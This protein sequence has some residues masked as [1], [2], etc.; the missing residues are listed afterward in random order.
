M[1]GRR[2]DA[3]GRGLDTQRLQEQ[4]QEKDQEQEQEQEQHK[5]SEHARA[6]NAFGNAAL[7]AMLANRAEGMAGDEGGGGGQSARRRSH[8]KEG[9]DYGGD[10]DVIDD[11]PISLDDLTRSWNP[12]TRKGEDKPRF[13]E[14]M[15]DDDLPPEDEAFLAD[16]A[17]APRVG[18]LPR[19]QT[20]DPLFEPSREVLITSTAA[21]SRACARF[22]APTPGWRAL[23][24]LVSE[25]PPVLQARGARVLPARAAVAA[26]GSCILAAAP[27]VRHAPT[28]ETGA[29]IHLCLELEGRHRR[30]DNILVQLEEQ[31]ARLPR[32]VALIEE[33][34]RPAGAPL[35][36]TSTPPG[37]AAPLGRSLST[38]TRWV[39]LEPTVPDFQSPPAP[40]P[41]PD[42]PLGL[43]AVFLDKLGPGPEAEAEIARAALRHAERLAGEASRTRIRWSAVALLVDEVSAAW[44]AHP[45]PLLLT[46]AR[47]LDGEVD[48]LL[49]LL[50]EVARACQQHTQPP[51]ALRNGLVRGARQLDGLRRQ[52][53]ELM[54]RLL[55]A[56]LPGHPDL[57][58]PRR[59]RPDPLTAADHPRDALPWARELPAGPDRDLAVLALLARAEASPAAL[60]AAA[61]PLLPDPLEP[62]IDPAAA[63]ALI[64]SG[65]A[66]LHAGDATTV[67]RHADTL[68]VLGRARRN[69]ILVAEAALLSM[70]A[71]ALDDHLDDAAFVRLEAARVCRALDAR[72]ALTLLARWRPHDED[73]DEADFTPFF[74][75]PFV[76]PLEPE[77]GEDEEEDEDEDEEEDEDEDEEQDEEQDEEGEDEEQDGEDDG[78]ATDDEGSA[79]PRA[80]PG[81]G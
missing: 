39:E 26:L 37:I 50:L 34:L 44:Y 76:D 11:V 66:A 49:K 4:Q 8:E 79:G 77:E 46:L 42:D 65:H 7:A 22:A 55:G 51:R 52:L 29:L 54:I 3:S 2:D 61:E 38:L 23:A 15:P 5:E 69:G 73:E 64:L 24:G 58:Q 56:I 17:A 43:D 62:G 13:V 40:E 1:A 36:P 18:P 70:E 78:P 59:I 57:P 25:A 27:P 28:L 20:I 74:D 41:D 9:V 31:T 75:Y 45:G 68:A 33:R 80:T 72:G 12:T 19:I 16:L 10:D 21:W 71:H 30:V 35:Q 63:V 6:Q 32:A 67:H 53:D 48:K 81:A 14:P 60:A 47:Q